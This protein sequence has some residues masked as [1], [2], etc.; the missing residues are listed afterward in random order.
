MAACCIWPPSLRRNDE[1]KR[2]AAETI[3]WNKFLQLVTRHRVAGLA[4]HGLSS[5]EQNMPS[6]IA[7]SLAE[8][9][10]SIASQNLSHAAETRRLQRLFDEASIPVVFVKGVSLGVLVYGSLGLKHGKDIDILAPPAFSEQTLKLLEEFDYRLCQPYCQF[11][12]GRRH[13]LFRYSKDAALINSRSG[14]E[15]ELHWGLTDNPL[16]LQNVDCASPKQIVAPTKDCGIRT[17]N[18]RD[19][20]AY[21]CVHGAM[22]GWS[23]LKWLADVGA[24]VAQRDD[25]E[26][27]ALY[28]HA[29]ACGAGLCAG[30]TLLLCEQ[31]LDWKLP[32]ALKIELYGNK[33]LG[34]L[35]AAAMSVMSAAVVEIEGNLG[36]KIR[37]HLRPFTLGRGRAFL[38]AQCK[39][40]S[41]MLV[42]VARIPLH[43]SLNFLYPFLGLP[44]WL[45]RRGP[46]LLLRTIAR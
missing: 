38:V 11:G 19:L 35:A 18:D 20:F 4:H 31:L 8:Q 43:P 28:R 27:V 23:R 21:L 15:V 17:L 41:V 22:H 3:D 34:Q 30:Q 10:K 42:D 5:V 45:W 6:T 33:R 44:L 16:L 2:A 37:A 26:I 12:E 39:V 32:A 13:L 7:E 14:V 9:A 24:L 29:Q 40:S 36:D 46:S 25:V 1:I